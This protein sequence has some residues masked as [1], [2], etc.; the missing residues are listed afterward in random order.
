[1]SEQPAT[2]PHY[3]TKDNRPEAE[4][5]RA[6]AEAGLEKRLQNFVFTDD[7][8]DTER[9]R[10]RQIY[11][12]RLDH[13]I[14][15][16]NDMGFPGYFLIVA[17][18][19]QW[20]KDQDIPVGP[21][22]GSGG[23]SV[24]AW[25]MN[26]IDI[27][28]VKYD[29]LF[30]RFLNPDR[31]SLP[32]FDIDF[33]QDRRDEVIGYVKQ[34]YGAEK[35][36]QIITF[37]KLQA[38]AVL[39]DVGRVLQMPYGQVDR[40]CKLVPNNPSN[41]MTL[42][43]AI[44]H[45]P[46]LRQM[47]DDDPT[48]RR[49]TDIGLKLE[50]LYR[51][52]STH[53]AGVVIGDRPLPE[54]LPLYQD[55]RSD[56]PATQFSMKYA[57][58]TGLVKFDFLGLKTLSIL[59]KATE[60]IEQ[61]EGREI[62]L[63]SLPMDDPAAYD[64]MAQ[65]NTVGV[66]QLESAGMQDALRRIQPS[67]FEDI[68]AI[69]SLY[70][71]GP[72]ENIPLYA[73]RKAGKADVQYP[74]PITRDVLQETYGII[75]YQEQVMKIAQDLAGY[76]LAQADIL[77]RAMGKKIK[78]VMDEQRDV[79]ITGAIENGIDKDKAVEIFNLMEKFASYG[80][81]KSHA[82]CYALIAYQTAYLKAHYP[83][84]FMA[85]LMCY[86]MSNTD[87]LSVFRQDIQ[88]MEI[89]L[90]PPDINQSQVYFSVEDT[91][92]PWEEENTEETSLGDQDSHTHNKAVRY[93]LGAVKGVGIAAMETVV[94][95]RDANGPY[96]RFADFVFRMDTSAVNRRQLEILA[97]A[98][99][100][101]QLDVT[102]AQAHD[103]ADY[104]TRIAAKHHAD[105]EAGQDSLFAAPNGGGGS[106]SHMELKVP[107]NL[108]WDPDEQLS[109][110]YEA[111][112]FY[113]TAHPLDHRMETLIDRGY[114]T[115][116][117]IYIDG[118]PS[119]NDPTSR[120]KIAGVVMDVNI[121]SSDRGRYAFVD[122]SDPTGRL[123]VTFYT[124]ALN[125]YTELLEEGRVISAEVDVRRK[126]DKTRLIAQ[127]VTPVD[128]AMAL[129]LSEVILDINGDYDNSQNPARTIRDMLHAS[130]GPS[131]ARV[132]FNIRHQDQVIQVQ[133]DRKFAISAP[134]LDEVANLDGIEQVIAN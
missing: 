108:A 118:R 1:L 109:H 129:G 123:D 91:S 35:V 14:G 83:V 104:A 20:A 110:E 114:L 97:A 41:P 33:C 67:E 53:A 77:R 134:F 48:V 51:H 98:G 65:G 103:M 56:M 36:A 85:A 68:I 7:M 12:E 78:S 111:I 32:D 18:F 130:D 107:D 29:L 96:D 115:A 34:K 126:D 86:D 119:A 133:L 120:A 15:I 16:I 3:E 31:V 26:I 44:D 9:E 113:L 70:R 21:G 84:E 88:S 131:M 102:R 57:E 27:D 59:N 69:V 87:K 28:P 74:H 39:R 43:E 24:V 10:L 101:D 60:F 75:V 30:E 37:G 17:D 94:A 112:G 105:Q 11:T 89:D 128:H 54:I 62:D 117:N 132:V 122:L 47:I 71:P 64:L 38:R 45:E 95:E 116:K 49:L 61:S 13:E 76:S 2:F 52:A 81:N 100:F 99:A 58:K 72:M 46:I 19:I 79:F 63:L 6:Q 40:I 5:M 106:T 55:P 125:E 93:A 82:A 50:G 4:E 92:P 80:F 73:D 124:E 25:A 66:F 127:S 8:E 121:R 90:L 42:Q 22:R 23:G